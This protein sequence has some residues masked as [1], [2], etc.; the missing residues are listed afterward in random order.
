VDK[1]RDITEWE[2]KVAQACAYLDQFQG[3]ETKATHLAAKNG[4]LIDDSQWHAAR[5]RRASPN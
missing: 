4:E 2:I 1:Q 5:M 3:D